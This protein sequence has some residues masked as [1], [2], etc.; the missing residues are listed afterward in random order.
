MSILGQIFTEAGVEQ[1]KLIQVV[2]L[3]RA[4]PMAAMVAVQELKLSDDVMKK[5]MVTVMMDP[6]AIE[7]LAK[8]LGLTEEDISAIKNKF[9]PN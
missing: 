3:L 2:N 5:I 7:D 9:N 4:N 6:H 1:Q 8:E